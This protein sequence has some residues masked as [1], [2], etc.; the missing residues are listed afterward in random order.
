V[1]VSLL[2]VLLE[3]DVWL[4]HASATRIR[5]PATTSISYAGTSPSL[6]EPKR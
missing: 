6:I 3:P 4:L 1:S 2:P 5:C